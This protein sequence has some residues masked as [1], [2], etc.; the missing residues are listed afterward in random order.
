[1]KRALAF[2][3]LLALVLPALAA[4]NDS[5]TIVIKGSNTFGEELGPRLIEVY[6]RLHPEIRIELESKGTATGIAALLAGECDIASTSRPANEDEERLARS[7]GIAFE[8]RVIGYFGVAIIVNEANPLRALTD[9]QVPD[10]FTGRITNWKQVR[11]S[12]API[13]L[14]IRDPSSGAHIGFRE[15][16]MRSLPYAATATA[17]KSYREIADAVGADKGGIGYVGINL[18][19]AG[20]VQPVSI[21]RELP[22]ALA[23]NDGV[24]PYARQLRLYTVKGKVSPAT[25]EFIKFV[26]SRRGQQ[27]LDVT[28][29]VPPIAAPVWPPPQ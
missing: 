11:G 23:V 25:Q 21:N 1:M 28:G 4:T 22:S 20:H 9:A 14:Y 24:Y 10:I 7:R 29:F 18:A 2:L 13:H 8:H 19:T 15:L 26:L 12:D 5:Q 16:A 3:C 17:L 6:Q 27:V